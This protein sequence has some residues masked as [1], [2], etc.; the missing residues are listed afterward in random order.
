MSTS[1]LAVLTK[2]ENSYRVIEKNLSQLIVKELK[3]QSN[4]PSDERSWITDPCIVEKKDIHLIFTSWIPKVVQIKRFLTSLRVSMEFIPDFNLEIKPEINTNLKNLRDEINEEFKNKNK[5][6]KEYLTYIELLKEETENFLN[7]SNKL[8]IKSLCEYPKKSEYNAR[9]GPNHTVRELIENKEKWENLLQEINV[10]ETFE[11]IVFKIQAVDS[12]S[13]TY[14]KYNPGIDG[15]K[16]WKPIQVP[17]STLNSY[18]FLKQ[19]ED[20]LDTDSKTKLLELYTK[21]IEEI[22]VQHPSFNIVSIS[23]CKNNLAIQRKGRPTTKSEILRKIVNGTKLGK[24]VEIMA[25]KETQIWR[26][27]PGEY[28]QNHNNLVTILN[29]KL[30]YDLLDYSKTNKIKNYKSNSNIRVYIPKSKGK[31][32]TLDIPTIKDRYIQ[33]LMLLVMEPYLEACGDSSSW[34]FR[35]GR[36]TNHAITQLAQILSIKN[37]IQNNQYKEKLSKSF[38][39]ALLKTK[40][41]KVI[42]DEN[43][44][45]TT[46]TK[47]R[48]DKS[49]L[50]V[51]VPTQFMKKSRTTFDDCI[52]KHILDADIKGCFDNISHDW[53]LKNV[54]ITK[55]YHYLMNEILKVNIVEIKPDRLYNIKTLKNHIWLNWGVIKHQNLKIEYKTILTKEENNKGIPQGGIIYPLFLN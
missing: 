21:L 24:L 17:K 14:G 1:N 35:P 54:P 16:F 13:K 6:K 25:R 12:L 41:A 32:L 2:L 49:Y 8:K 50:Q 15:D 37:P 10:N 36:N 55:E 39:K 28:L 5:I 20:T 38:A 9:Y 31:V 48:Y 45:T 47:T 52:T 19:S 51:E 27:N 40:E 23:K 43:T 42:I 53:L 18:L 3:R 11:S 30:K 26:K 34:G 22:K 7:N 46:V 44:E 33:Q 29:T 4:I